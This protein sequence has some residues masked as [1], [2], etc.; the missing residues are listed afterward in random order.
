[1]SSF[2]GGAEVTNQFEKGIYMPTYTSPLHVCGFTLYLAFTFVA[3]VFILVA[4]ELA[5]YLTGPKD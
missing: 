2:W 1:M 4:K 5:D 3:M